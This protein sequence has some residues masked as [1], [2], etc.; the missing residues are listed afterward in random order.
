M[1]PGNLYNKKG[2]NTLNHITTILHKVKPFREYLVKYELG[3]ASFRGINSAKTT[4]AD[5]PSNINR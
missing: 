2:R 1:I 5:L 3:Y 4:E